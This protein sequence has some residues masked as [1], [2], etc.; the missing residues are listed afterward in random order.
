ME[1]VPWNQNGY[2]LC[3][4]TPNTGHTSATVTDVVCPRATAF[5]PNRRLMSQWVNESTINDA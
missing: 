2:A 1:G 5:E 3:L 4:L